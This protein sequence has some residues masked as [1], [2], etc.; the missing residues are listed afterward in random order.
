M[1]YSRYRRKPRRT[2]RKSGP[3]RRYSARPSR[4]TAK[5][6]RYTRKRP[7]SKKRILN[8]TSE[9]KRDKMLS[10][11]NSTAASQSGGTTYA[12][13]PAILTGGS[14][15]PAVFLWCAT[16]RG[17]TTATGGPKGSKF[18]MSTR[19]ATEC[20]MVGLKECIEIQVDN[21]LPWQW[22]RICFTFK[23][24]SN[25]GGYAP[26]GSTS[27]SPATLTSNGYV[28]V[29][30]QLTAAQQNVFF[31]L[32][33]QGSQDVDWN[34]HL[35]AKL[36]TE[37]ISVKY[38]KT[39]TISSGN[40]EG[41][42]RKYNKWHPMRHNLMYDDDETGGSVEVNGFSTQSRRGMGDYW[43]IDIIKPRVGSTSANQLLFN[44]E[45]TLYWH[46]K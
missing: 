31:R 14:A 41:V 11:S 10:F 22:R 16:G 25:I 28:R 24:G 15:T 13:T 33:M 1:A 40:E 34:D 18:D 23:G 8:V 46:E 39:C 4:Y 45:S 35:T 26:L 37:R 21:G 44:C 17:A 7:M 29:L 20:Y 9:K 36:D 42:I 30:N 19:T 2:Y 43:I 32:V 6:R 12:Q 5:T 3:K 38:D 27:Y